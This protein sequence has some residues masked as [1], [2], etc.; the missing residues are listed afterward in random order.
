LITR[1]VS[2]YIRDVGMGAPQIWMTFMLGAAVAPAMSHATASQPELIAFDDRTNGVFYVELGNPTGKYLVAS[3]ASYPA[4]SPDGTR[5]AFFKYLNNGTTANL[6]IVDRAGNTLQEI[7]TGKA[8]APSW[9]P[10]AT[11][12]AYGCTIPPGIGIDAVCIVDLATEVS[13]FAWTETVDDIWSFNSASLSWSPA[14]DRIAMSVEH[15]VPCS[16]PESTSTCRRLAVGSTTPT[17]GFQLLTPPLGRAASG[18]F[19]P[20]GLKL[21]YFDRDLGIRVADSAGGGATTIVPLEHATLSGGSGISQVA[22]SPDGSEVLWSTDTDGAQSGNS[23]FFSVAADGTG[24][25]FHRVKDNNHSWDPSWAP[26]IPACT[27]PGTPGD[28]ELEG[29]EGGDV[30]CGDSGHDDIEGRDGDDQI[31]GGTGGDDIAGGPGEDTID[32]GNGDDAVA[33]VDGETDDITCGLGIDE[34]FADHDD[35]VSSDCETVNRGGEEAVCGDATGD[36]SLTASDA[37]ST[38]RTAVGSGACEEC[39]CDVDE[40]GSVSASDALAVL[41]AAVGQSVDLGCAAC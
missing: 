16:D 33:A 23:D 15:K 22:W 41:R 35:E 25:Y 27:V 1:H 24:P 6:V 18:A 32:A 36:S 13:R 19:S 5:L 30:I 34:V 10:D 11:E 3:G 29:T 14:G 7:D 37:L 20:D 31:Y 21:A 12:I 26:S 4:W 28:D 2:R 39:V 8:Q 9:S 40:N 17:G 38:L